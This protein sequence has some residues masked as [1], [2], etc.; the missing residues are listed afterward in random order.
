MTNTHAFRRTFKTTLPD[1]GLEVTVRK[2]DLMKL[3]LRSKHIPMALRQQV[4]AALNGKVQ[5]IEQVKEAVTRGDFDL[6]EDNAPEYLKYWDMLATEMLVEPR[7]TDKPDYDNGEISADDLSTQ[8]KLYLSKLAQS[9][10]EVAQLEALLS[11]RHEQSGNVELAPDV[12][13]VRTAPVN[14]F[15]A[16]G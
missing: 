1:C 2:P 12:Q 15:G 14:G 4:F 7:I 11:F 6:N 3:A 5:S 9:A 8:D 16:H 10:E 13:A